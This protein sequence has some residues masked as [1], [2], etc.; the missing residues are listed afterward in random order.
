[1]NITKTEGILMDMLVKYN[2]IY[3]DDTI[4]ELTRLLRMGELVV[5]TAEAL[6]KPPKEG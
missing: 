1:M 5:S 6:S 3:H 2:T 4:D